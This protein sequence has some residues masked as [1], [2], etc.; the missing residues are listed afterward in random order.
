MEFVLLDWTRMGRVYCLA[1][2]VTQAGQVRIV[3]PLPA[4]G[5]D[6]PVNN[7]GWSPFLMDG[8]CRWEVFELI[9]PTPACA[10]APHLEDVWVQSLK[11]CGRLATREQRRDVLLAT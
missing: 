4:R 6:N 5:R 2:A 10:L 9:Q 7:Q 8:H 3:R 1:G 11:P